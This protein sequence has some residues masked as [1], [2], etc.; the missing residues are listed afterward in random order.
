[1][2]HSAADETVYI[3]VN[4]KYKAYGKVWDREALPY[5]C[6]FVENRQHCRGIRAIEAMPALV[7]L[8]SAI[9]ASK[10]EICKRIAEYMKQLQGQQF[11]YWD[12]TEMV[13]KGVRDTII[14]RQRE[15]IHTL[16]HGHQH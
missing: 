3:K 8:E 1:M 13:S 2:A 5:G 6:W 11:S 14:K 10:D 15:M 16:K 7:E 9:E 4:N 12:L